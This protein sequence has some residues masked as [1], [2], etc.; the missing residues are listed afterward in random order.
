M[1]QV[2]NSTISNF[3]RCKLKYKMN[4]EWEV[5]EEDKSDAL[6]IGTA[7]HKGMESWDIKH[8]EDEAVL[9]TIKSIPKEI[10]EYT[11][12][13]EVAYACLKLGIEYNLNN[14]QDIAA[15]E[16]EFKVPLFK[17]VVLAGRIDALILKEESFWVKERKTSG[18]SPDVFFKG[19]IMDK[20][21]LTYTWAAKQKFDKDVKG[22]CVEGVFKP[23]AKKKGF[24][25]RRYFSYTQEEVDVWLADTVEIATEMLLAHKEDN[26]FRSYNCEGKYGYCEFWDYCTTGFN[27]NVLETTHVRKEEVVNKNTKKKGGDKNG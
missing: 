12:V 11:E 13:G 3:S 16:V 5:K 7:Y 1:L 19:Y 8:D 24:V 20:Q 18:K 17:G 6:L 25:E 2:R 10:E 26:F 14:P 27:Q 4:L 21:A 23:T 9:E 15:T 22:V